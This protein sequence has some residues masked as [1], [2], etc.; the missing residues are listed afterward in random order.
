MKVGNYSEVYGT[1]Y[2]KQSNDTV[3]NGANAANV[4]NSDSIQNRLNIIN[5]QIKSLSEDENMSAEEKLRKQEQLREEQEKLRRELNEAKMAE[6]KEKMEEAREKASKNKEEKAT[7]TEDTKDTTTNIRSMEG[8]IG[9]SDAIKSVDAMNDVRDDL[10]G[11]IRVKTSHMETDAARG[12]NVEKQQEAIE[13][14]ENQMER[15]SG[16]VSEKMEEADKGMK[17]VIFQGEDGKVKLKQE[18]NENKL[19]NSV[20]YKLDSDLRM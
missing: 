20:S 16:N 18:K 10:D 14:L 3:N 2:N 15:I 8:F 7:A 9:A 11:T 12:S 6:R 5:G 4:K 13:K 17:K 1:S 19:H